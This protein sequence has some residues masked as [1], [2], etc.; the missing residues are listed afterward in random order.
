MTNKKEVN[1]YQDRHSTLKI[2]TKN[3]I[4]KVV[5]DITGASLVFQIKQSLDINATAL[6]ERKNTAAGGDATEIEDSNLTNG[7]YKVHLIPT[8]VADLGKFFCEV[9]MTLAAKDTTIFQKRFNVVPVV[10]D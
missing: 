5:V 8:H 7:E 2:T 10:I 9:K 6:V 1:V 4:T 3:P